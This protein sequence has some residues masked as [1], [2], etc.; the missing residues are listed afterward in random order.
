[1]QYK[2]RVLLFFL[3]LF[4]LVPNVSGAEKKPKYSCEPPRGYQ[5]HK[6]EDWGF[7]PTPPNIKIA[8][9]FKKGHSF[10]LGGMY[11]GKS[12]YDPGYDGVLWFGYQIQW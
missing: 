7:N 5:R 3:T 2:V 9:G 8:P 6:D 12:G 11:Y 4:A 1:M 10:R